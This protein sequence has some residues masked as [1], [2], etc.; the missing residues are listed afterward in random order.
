MEASKIAEGDFYRRDKVVSK[1]NI[2]VA[3]T[4]ELEASSQAIKVTLSAT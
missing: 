4:D 1:N 2:R 3:S